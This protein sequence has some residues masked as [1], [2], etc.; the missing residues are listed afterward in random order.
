[1]PT[2]CCLIYRGDMY[3]SGVIIALIF[4]FLIFFLQGIRRRY[5]GSDSSIVK[6]VFGASIVGMVV[7]IFS[8]L[9][10]LVLVV[11]YLQEK[12]GEYQ[13]AIYKNKLI[14]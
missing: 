13:N 6:I 4:S 5:E 12:F 7:S 11:C 3:F 1:M 8:W 9:A 10:V 14:C 2:E